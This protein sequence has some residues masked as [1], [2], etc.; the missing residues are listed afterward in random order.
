MGEGDD[1]CP[2]CEGCGSCIECE[3]EGNVEI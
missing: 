2:E 1:D 3:G